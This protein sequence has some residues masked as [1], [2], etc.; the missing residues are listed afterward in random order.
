MLNKS[1]I[2]ILLIACSCNWAKE[3]TKETLNK[4]GEV[5]AKTGSEFI[6]GVE[7]GV[8]KTF[9]HKVELSEALKAKKLSTGKILILSTDTTQDNIL[10]VY[11]IFDSDF[12]QEISL[13]IIDDL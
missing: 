5:V 11:F 7:K 10:S 9:K 4:T 8:E 1:Y 12:N 6:D 13:K 2:Y 3:K